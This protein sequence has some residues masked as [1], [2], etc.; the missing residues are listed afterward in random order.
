MRIPCPPRRSAAGRGR[1]SDRLGG[2]AEQ[3]IGR[4]SVPKRSP[5]RTI[6]DIAFCA[7]MVPSITSAPSQQKSQLPHVFGGLAEIGEQ[8]LAPAARQFA[9]RDQRIEALPVDALLL[10]ARLALLDLHPAQPHVAHA[11]ERQRIGWQPVAAG[12]ADLLV[13]ALDVGGHVGV[14][15]KRTSG[16]SMPM[17]NAT[18]AAITTPSSCRKASWLRD[19]RRLHAGMIGERVDAFPSDNRRAPRSCGATRN[20]RCRFGRAGRR[21]IARSGYGR[22]PWPHC[23]PQVGPV[24]AV[25]EQCWRPVNSL[26]QMS[27]RVAASAVAVNA[28][29]CTPPNSRLHRAERRI[30][31]PEVVAPLRDAVRLVDRQQRD[32]GALSSST[33]SPSPVARAP[34]RQDAVRR[35]RSDRGWRGSPPDR[36]RSS[37]RRRDPV[38]AKLRHL[39]AHQR[40]QRRDH[41]REPVRI[42]AGS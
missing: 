27:P 20:R 8:G 37:G 36:S 29:V 35:A 17:P 5:V 6:A 34:Y 15:T 11:V 13:I 18:V 21:G 33:V 1:I 10:V 42:S 25:D 4:C 19:G 24:E 12:A 23:E 14:E 3:D 26:S 2:L 41:H 39:I 40:D 22:R 28:T 9:Q 32:L 7:A 31:G 16:L 38:A 30:F